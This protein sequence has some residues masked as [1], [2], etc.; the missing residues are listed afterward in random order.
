MVTAAADPKGPMGRALLASTGIHVLAALLIPA[1]AFTMTAAAPVETITFARVARIQI[2]RPQ[3]P[4]PQPRAAAPIR[5]NVKVISETTRLELAHTS[6]HR[7]SSPPPAIT[8]RQSMAPQVA[9]APRAGSGTTEGEAAPQSTAPPQARA[10]SSTVGRDTGGYSPFGAQLPDPVLDPTV[11]KQL[12]ALGVHVTLLVTV[13]EDGHTKTVQFQPSVDPQLES[14]IQT[15]LSD[16]SWD[17]A[18]CGGG[19]ACEGQATIKL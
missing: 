17:P 15:L 3:P 7:V 16:A 6:P 12:T 5:S 13:G 19:I 9:A 4:Q 11:R 18:V 14:R 8:Y 10:V 1:L 2:Q